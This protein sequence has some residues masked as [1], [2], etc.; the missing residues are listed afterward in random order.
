M[1]NLPDS[2]RDS[3]VEPVSRRHSLCRASIAKQAP[4][5]LERRVDILLAASL[6]QLLV[7]V[8]Y[9]GANTRQEPFALANLR[10]VTTRGDVLIPYDVRYVL[11]GAKGQV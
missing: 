6:G 5:L 7:G 8:I 9:G 10:L 2:C 4:R 3:A 11:A 1:P